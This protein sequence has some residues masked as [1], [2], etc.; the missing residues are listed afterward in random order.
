MRYLVFVYGTLKRDFSLHRYL[1]D[2]KFV[3]KASL[4]GYEMYDFGW[5]PGIVPGKGT[6]F[7]EVYEID[8]KTLFILDE[9]EDEGHEYERK[10]LPVKLDDGKT[11]HAFVYV[12]KGPVKNK[13]RVKDG[14]WQK[15]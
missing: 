6:V 2:A 4:S 11:L 8:L 7:G 14:R 13:P 5:Y 10:I 12:Y 1:K 15:K 3:G 9:V